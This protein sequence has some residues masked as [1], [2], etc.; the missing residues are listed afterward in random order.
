MMKPT[1]L[2]I[3]AVLLI[4]LIG[5]AQAQDTA[6]LLPN[7]SFEAGKA[8]PA[9]WALKGAGSWGQEIAA[10]GTRFVT[11][12]GEGGGQWRSKPIAFTPGA[13]YELRFRCRYRPEA[14]FGRG[15]AV[16]GPDF[17]IR[18]I[19]LDASESMPQWRQHVMRF[20]APTPVDPAT[21]SIGLGQWRLKGAIDYDT[22]EL[23]PIKLAHRAHDGMTLGEGEALAGNDYRF[24]APLT[25]WRTISRPLVAY[26]DRFHDNRWRFTKPTASVVYRHEIVGRKQTRASVQPNVWFHQESTWQLVVEAS[27][28][29]QD[30]TLLGRSGYEELTPSF[31]V[32]AEMLPAQA[33]W[34]R[35]RVDASD[36][37]MPTFFQV[38]GYEYD[39][40]VDGPS[41]NA[42]GAT[43]LVT[44]LGEDPA[45][46]ATPQASDPGAPAF[47]VQVTNR[48][49]RAVTIEPALKVAHEKGPERTLR[50]AP[51]QL[52]AG[53]T[54]RVA[55]PYDAGAAGRYALDFTLGPGLRTRLA[56]ESNVAIL[57][58]SNYGER[59]SSPDS[60]VALWW[61]SSGWKISRTRR[62]PRARGIGVKLSVARNEAEGAQ[63]VVR[64]SRRLSGLTATA[65]ELRSAAGHVLPADAV[66]V[67]RVRYV[68][69]EYVSDAFGCTGDW[70][71][72]LPPFKGGID[73]AAGENQP[74]WVRVRV[75]KDAAAGVYR[76]VV[77]LRADGFRATVPLEVEVYGFTLPDTTTCRS[78]FGF[79]SGNVIRYHRLKT[80]TDQRTVID[81]YLRCF[82]EH[83]IS[84][85]NPAPLDR[86]SYT[87]QTHMPWDGG[88]L[89]MGNAH[90]G[91]KSL[92]VRDDS[93]TSNRTAHYSELLPISGKPLRISLWRR[94]AD[95]VEPAAM[96]LCHYDS[97]RKWFY[98]K[99]RHVAIPAST[100]WARFEAT[101]PTFPKGTANVRV[102]VQ[103]CRYSE[104]G[105]RT[106][107]VWLDDVSVVDTGT[108]KE[109]IENGD[110]EAAEPAGAGT[111]IRFDWGAWDAA[112]AKAADDYHFNSF[113]FRVPGLGGGTFYA[114]RKGSLLGYKQDTPEHLALFRT[115]CNAARDHLAA[116][117]LLDKAVCYPFDEPAPKDYA[118]VVE[119]LRFLKSNFPGLRRMVPMNL[120]AANDFVGHIDYWC[121][122][123]AS[124]SRA[125]AAKRREAGEEY[126]WYI[127]CGPK[128]PYIA[129]FIDRAATDLRVWLWQTWQEGVDGILIWESVYW[130]SP[131][132]YPKSLQ[133]PYEDSM[134]WVRGYGTQ[135]GQRRRWN[136]G[137]GRFMYPPE[138]ATGAQAEAILDGPVTSIRWEALRDGIEDY[139]YLALLKRLLAA[140]SGKLAAQEIKRYEALLTVPPDISAS[141]TSYTRGPAPIAARRHEIAKAI[142]RLS[143]R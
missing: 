79:G 29:G 21:S 91:A 4:S 83:R 35:L 128:A 70:P 69:V 1:A 82:S 112:M 33:V 109:L 37:A 110:F 103:G 92:L 130:H 142:E 88:K 85:Y 8:G 93:E 131:P 90:S 84:P 141:L 118:F 139:E 105:E 39:A 113:V 101:V 81:K 40:T 134:S 138:A 129:N 38:N 115:W 28:N 27:T 97:G 98:G 127:C 87:W 122:I 11:V 47:V 23:H 76:G 123:L 24:Q 64:P 18:V 106:G 56:A 116:K 58:A 13:V 121:P 89:V 3:L 140:K 99:N 43:A 51:F 9:G 34:V 108:G 100:G 95:G 32:P 74:L 16:V 36:N 17:A 133:N 117:G 135:P 94:T 53:G 59:L 61:A 15:Y 57:H 22:L 124:H 80:D 41:C 86:Y 10:E 119:Q 96:Y 46:A 12:T 62:V 77:S 132:A 49:A 137:D 143:A 102:M 66:G 45:I 75:P 60:S 126:T 63:I 2:T 20:T 107:S 52:A 71:D 31:E 136:A 55:V 73:L 78:L 65:G 6:V 120:G 125:F 72:P 25:R 30:Y 26:N 7:P 50:A 67:L 14:L 111:G 42:T 114:R 44:V 68:N 104:E 19:P 5:M 54:T 48:G